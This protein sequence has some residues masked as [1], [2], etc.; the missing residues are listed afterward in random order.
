MDDFVTDIGRPFG[1]EKVRIKL[2]N[3]RKIADER[4]KI[5][6]AKIGI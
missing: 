2:K 4:K 5:R 1:R 3:E 6:L